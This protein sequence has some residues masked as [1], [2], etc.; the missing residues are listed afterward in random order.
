M[1]DVS[2]IRDALPLLGQG[3]WRE[4]FEPAWLTEE[5]NPRR[6]FFPARNLPKGQATHA[7]LCGGLG[8]AKMRAAGQ[9]GGPQGKASAETVVERL[10]TARHRTVPTFSL[11]PTIIGASREIGES[12][13]WTSARSRTTL[14]GLDDPTAGLFQ[15]LAGALPCQHD[16]TQS[17]SFPPPLPPA[18]SA[19]RSRSRVCL[20]P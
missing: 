1:C 19:S 6:P 8:V 7:R 3:A 15:S 5:I 11:P 14:R 18:P 12:R 13:K 20:L 9:V 4:F 2:S 16:S 10:S 17:T